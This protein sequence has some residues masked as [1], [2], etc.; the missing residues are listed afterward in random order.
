MWRAL[1]ALILALLLLALTGRPA[2]AQ[3]AGAVHR[4]VGADGAAIFTDRACGD[5]QAQERPA[6]LAPG[7]GGKTVAVRGCA[8]TPGDLVA[9]VRAALDA[10]DVNRLAGFYLWTGMGTREAYG[11]MDELSR[12]SAHPLV[13]ARL[14]RPDEPPPEA[15]A[16]TE[17]GFPSRAPT[18]AEQ[19]L[20]LAPPPAAAPGPRPAPRL[21]VDQGTSANDAS[22]RVSYFRLAPQAG[23]WW[24]HY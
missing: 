6:P 8:R 22:A 24:I 17:S 23:C 9:G 20:G 21:R 4:C 5:L 19:S 12:L 1:P 11:V 14:V 7:H 10:Q 2:D 16:F 3:T 15:D 18:S 13:D